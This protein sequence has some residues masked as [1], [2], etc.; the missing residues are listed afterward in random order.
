LVYELFKLTPPLKKD[1]EKNS[2]N[3]R[4]L[5]H[6]N[7]QLSFQGIVMNCK[8]QILLQLQVITTKNNPS[9]KKKIKSSEEKDNDL[10]DDWMA[11][12]AILCVVS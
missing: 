7:K 5:E 10:P 9:P 3:N 1:C 12:Q 6:S 4:K 8:N 11:H 2:I